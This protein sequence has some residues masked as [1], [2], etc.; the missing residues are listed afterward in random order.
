MAGQGFQ[1]LEEFLGDSLDLPIRCNDGQVRT[2][3]IPP[4]SAEDGMRVETIMETGLRL[5][6]GGAEPD[7]EVLDDAAE[8]DL[9]RIALGSAHDELQ[10]HLAWPRFRH[11]AI[12]SVLWITQGL[13]TAEQYWNSGGDP[14]LMA[15]NR[16]ARRAS[17]AAASSTPRRGSTSGTST[18]R[19]T[20]RPRKAAKT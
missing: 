14:S 20:A 12:T 15:P 13:D 19:A 11:V 2:F 4:C 6:A 3:H 1:V 7:T 16:A 18:P 9:Y 10:Q 8:M 17:S 5:A